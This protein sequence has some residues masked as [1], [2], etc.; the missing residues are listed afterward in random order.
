MREHEDHHWTL[1]FEDNT[2]RYIE[3]GDEEYQVQGDFVAVLPE[4]G[5]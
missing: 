2:G 1:Q 3:L 4:E 5:K